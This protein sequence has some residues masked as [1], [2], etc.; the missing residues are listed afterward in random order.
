[1]PLSRLGLA[2]LLLASPVL[3]ADYEI[4]PDHS[5]VGFKVKHLAISN[6]PGGF[7]R[8]GGRFSF[9][10]ARPEAARVEAAISTSSIDTRHGK[11]DEH[12]RSPDF[13]DTAR[14][15]EITFAS[16]EVREASNEGFKLLGDLTIKGVTKPVTLDVSITGSG[17]DMYGKERAAFSATTRINRK[18]FG[19]TWSKVLETGALVVGDDVDVTIDIEGI[20]KG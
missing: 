20:K 7:S 18:E 15:P 14:F 10:P 3:A 9:D 19:L 13:F 1:M 6:V 16:R 17:K 12:L 2:V 11:R 4:D 5:S 8:F